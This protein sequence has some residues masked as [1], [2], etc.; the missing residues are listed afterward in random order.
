[1]RG[2]CGVGRNS[3]NRPAPLTAKLVH[4]LLEQVKRTTDIDRKS[5]LPVLLTEL[6]GRAHAQNSRRIDQHVQS[7]R[8]S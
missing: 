1:M 5:L 6:I 8:F 4:G 3:N 2:V 7:L